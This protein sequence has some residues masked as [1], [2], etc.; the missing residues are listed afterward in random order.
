MK[1]SL[2]EVIEA[3]EEAD[4]DARYFYVVP[5]EKIIPGEEAEEYDDYDLIELPDKS[6]RDDYRTMERFINTVKDETAAEW[7]ANAIKGRGAFRRFRGTLERFH[8]TSD[9]YDYRDRCIRVLAMRWCEDNGIEYE[10]SYALEKEDLYDDDDW[11][12][13][14]EEPAAVLPVIKKEKPEY[15]IVAIT[16]RNSPS[17]TLLAA[18]CTDEMNQTQSDPDE[19]EERIS[20][21]LNADHRVTAV[22]D[23]GK[24]LGYCVLDLS[25]D[26]PYIQE[27]FVRKEERR[28]GIGTMLIRDAQKTAYEEKDR[29]LSFKVN[30]ENRNM[31]AFLDA[32]G[33][34]LVRYYEITQEE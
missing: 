12:E 28:K 5:E 15:R 2:N 24:F 30:P 8:L 4:E 27:I 16:R 1:I 18:D 14:E 23:R 34:S 32:L 22:S 19:A 33:Y 20:S 29:A 21:Y 7:L 26:T 31:I 9:W 6:D 11:F 3:I 25:Y 17:L 10:S 13:E